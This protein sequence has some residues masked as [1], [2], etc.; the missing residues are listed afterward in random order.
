MKKHRILIIEDDVDHAFLEEDILLDELA[1]EVKIVKSRAELSAEEIK[2]AQVILLDFNL[3]DATGV[4][5][6]NDIRKISDVPVLVI[7]GDDQLQ[8]AI[9]TLKT[10]A[11]DFLVKSPQ[12]IKILP[13]LVKN[14]HE[15]HIKTKK[16]EDIIKQQDKTDTKIETLNQVLTT[17]AHYIN[18][19]T[20]TIYGYAQLCQQNPEDT[21]KFDKL[22]EVSIKETKKISL[23]LQEL[24]NFVNTS[25]IRTTNYI[26]IPEAM[27]AIEENIK[28]KMD[29]L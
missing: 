2:K 10:G 22:A 4:D 17:L 6:L 20:T 24:E 26:D 14:V 29:K 18:N 21:A 12:N 23:V 1:C 16:K 5:V 15:V 3:P 13:Q 9:D 28:K 27:F 25:E 11:T 19:S 8:T 7:T